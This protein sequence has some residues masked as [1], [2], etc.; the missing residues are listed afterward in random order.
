MA[1]IILPDDLKA[2]IVSTLAKEFPISGKRCELKELAM[3][4]EKA[5]QFYQEYWTNLMRQEN[6]HLSYSAVYKK[7]LENP[8]IV[9]GMSFASHVMGL[10]IAPGNAE[11]KRWLLN[12]LNKAL[13]GNLL[14]EQF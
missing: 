5:I 12:V 7:S 3:V 6:K 2:A 8:Q 4:A 11:N 14:S 9:C 10:R 13:E 1:N